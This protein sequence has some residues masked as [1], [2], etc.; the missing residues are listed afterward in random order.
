[1]PTAVHTLPCL[2]D[3][4]WAGPHE[5][6]TWAKAACSRR[7]RRAN[8]PRSSPGQG[9]C[10]ANHATTRSSL[11]PELL[12]PRRW[13]RP[14][15]GHPPATAPG[16]KARMTSGT[17]STPASTMTATQQA[18]RR[19]GS[20]HRPVAGPLATLPAPSATARISALPGRTHR[21]GTDLPHHHLHTSTPAR[22]TIEIVVSIN[23]LKG[24]GP[25]HGQVK[26]S[27]NI[28]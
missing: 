9:A 2:S 8:S 5:L 20:G 1:M 19:R 16:A 4:V 15:H 12:L 7:V 17:L 27:L 25:L 26:N 6:R 24:E 10:A 21:P 22:P 23:V 28:E 3:F 18:A 11:V 14:E 13:H